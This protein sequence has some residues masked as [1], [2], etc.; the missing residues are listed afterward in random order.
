MDATSVAAAALALASPLSSMNAAT[1]AALAV[2][3]EDSRDAAM[4]EV[5]LE[6][7]RLAMSVADR[8]SFIAQKYFVLSAQLYPLASNFTWQSAYARRHNDWVDSQQAMRAALHAVQRGDDEA[9]EQH[10]TAEVGSE[11]TV[12]DVNTEADAMEE[13]EEE[14]DMEE[15]AEVSPA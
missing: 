1:V 10:L 7:E 11:Q 6:R 5:L 14:E 12:E 3:V 13:E 2:V 9:A 4:R 15:D 8:D